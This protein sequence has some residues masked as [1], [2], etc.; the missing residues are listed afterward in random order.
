MTETLL[1]TWNFQVVISS[2]S[3]FG[4]I[5]SAHLVFFKRASAF[6]NQS[7]RLALTETRRR[8]N[9]TKLPIAWKQVCFGYRVGARRRCG[10]I[11]WSWNK[12]LL[13]MHLI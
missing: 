6:Q 3:L 13:L 10:K 11:C 5:L 4:Q 12:D 1:S 7:L 8:Q 9:V 2:F